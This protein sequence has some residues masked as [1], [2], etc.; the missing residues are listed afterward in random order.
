MP[1]SGMDTSSP[2]RQGLGWEAGYITSIKQCRVVKEK[3]KKKK[4]KREEKRSRYLQ[5]LKGIHFLEAELGDSLTARKPE[6]NTA[7]YC[8]YEY[9][10]MC[11]Y[12]LFTVAAFLQFSFTV[13]LTVVSTQLSV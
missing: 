4:K 6:R 2:W 1:G 11:F 10:L 7:E 3:K 5:R 8:I 9:F 13:S 12:S